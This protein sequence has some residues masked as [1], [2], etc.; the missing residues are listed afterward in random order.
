MRAADWFNAQSF[1]GRLE[2]PTEPQPAT[3]EPVL[4]YDRWDETENRWRHYRQDENG[5][6]E[7]DEIGCA[8]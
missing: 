1:C 7:T 4:T 8:L 6:T 2:Q 5:T 3:K